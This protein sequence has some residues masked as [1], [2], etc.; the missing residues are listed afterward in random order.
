MARHFL[1]LYLLIVL[2]LTAVS[3]G[4]DRLLQAYGNQGAADDKSL[5]VALFAFGNQLH[6]V[7]TDQWKRI[8]ADS[9]AKTGV[10]MELFATTDIAGRETLA[11]LKGGEI[12]YMQSAAG[13]S[14][15]LKQLDDNYVLA[16]RSSE[17]ETQRGLLEWTLTLLFYAAIA[18]VI[19][20][21]I[22]PLTRD[23]RALEKAASRFGNKT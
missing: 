15:A 21:W 11:K 23:L 16:L 18:L 6:G 1:S 4:Q 22:W 13:Q 19:M 12:S 20:I 8:V 7:P 2:T 9:A 14:W 3:W 5:A 10:D 17:P